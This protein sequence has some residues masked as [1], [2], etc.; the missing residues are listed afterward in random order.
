MVR[1]GMP[2][3]LRAILLMLATGFCFV[4]MQAAAKAAAAEGYDPIQIVWARFTLHLLGV[5]ALTP[6]RPT[7]LVRTPR[8]IL[9]ALRGGFL[10]GSTACAFAA[11]ARMPLPEMS[12]I[13][14]SAP[15]MVMVLAASLL[16][17]KVGWRRW[18][19]AGTGFAGVVAVVRP[20]SVTLSDGTV[21]AFGM[22]LFYALYQI[23]TRAL[24]AAAPPLTALFYAAFVGAVAS[25]LLVPFFWR[26][27]DPL[28]WLLLA[29]PAL[30]GGVGQYLL[31]RAYALAPANL[32]APFMYVE[33][34]WSLMF[35]L[36][37]FGFWPDGRTLMGAAVIIA[38]GLYIWHRERVL[39]RS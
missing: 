13:T 17:E 33:L 15:L 30:F 19:A 11:L 31:I 29:L 2:P 39:G 10:V 34:I 14:F 9:Q 16:G 18:V 25:S 35:G 20:E 36:T 12:V 8:P 3:V 26:A 5:I 1:T 22:A 38:S 37:V 32:L 28:G 27:P 24:A 21:F 4:S 7:H 6:M 23:A